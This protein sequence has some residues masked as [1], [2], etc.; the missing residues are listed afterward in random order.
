MLF[1]S[2]I[3]SWIWCLTCIKIHSN[4]CNKILFLQTVEEEEEAM[5]DLNTTE[6][7]VVSTIKM[8]GQSPTTEFKSWFL[9]QYILAELNSANTMF[10]PS[11][12][13]FI[14]HIWHLREAICCITLCHV[15]FQ[16]IKNI[17][18]KKCFSLFNY[19]VM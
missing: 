12:H 6:F 7:W 17:S 4:K 11:W 8:Y 13:Q 18:V 5:S 14:H 9:F 1:H 15:L 19:T 16:T 3:Q 2:R 10:N